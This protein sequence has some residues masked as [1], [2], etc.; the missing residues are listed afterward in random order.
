MSVC[1]SHVSGEDGKLASQLDNHHDGTIISFQL[2]LRRVRSFAQSLPK[3]PCWSWTHSR[4]RLVVWGTGG[5]S[6]SPQGSKAPKVSQRRRRGSLF[7]RPEI[8][9]VNCPVRTVLQEQQQQQQQQQRCRSNSS[10]MPSQGV[11]K[12]PKMRHSESSG[13]PPPSSVATQ[14]RSS[15]S[16]SAQGGPLLLVIS[17]LRGPF[18]SPVDS[19][20]GSLTHTLSLRVHRRQPLKT[21]DVQLRFA[22]SVPSRCLFLGAAPGGT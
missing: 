19:S 10:R 20:G 7:A 8:E 22:P 12:G 21:P 6:L 9:T 16:S 15:S 5:P 17:G 14:P 3:D 11:P 13:P 4:A 2:H 18:S 1:P